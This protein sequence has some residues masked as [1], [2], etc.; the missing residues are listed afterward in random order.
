MTTLRPYQERGVAAIR[1]RYS[2]GSRAVLYQAPCGSGKLVARRQGSTN[3][4]IRRA[5]RLSLSRMRR[6]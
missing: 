6:A 5:C 4:C 2:G 3:K 1:G